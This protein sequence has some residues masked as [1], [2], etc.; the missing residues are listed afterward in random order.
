MDSE[1]RLISG[2]FDS[3]PSD[4]RPLPSPQLI[5]WKAEIERKRRLAE[6]STAPV[7]ATKWSVLAAAGVMLMIFLAPLGWMA[8]A[9]AAGAFALVFAAAICATVLA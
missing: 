5:W 8:W 2:F 4:D 6:R 7:Q 1:D 9:L 3:V